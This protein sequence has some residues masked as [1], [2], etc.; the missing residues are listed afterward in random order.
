MPVALPVV[1]DPMVKPLRVMVNDEAELMAA[2]AVVM[3]MELPE[4]PEV[5]VN[6]ATEVV[7]AVLFAG[8]GVAAMKLAG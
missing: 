3:T 1:P 7:P 6:D 4:I 8:L 5:A 2:P